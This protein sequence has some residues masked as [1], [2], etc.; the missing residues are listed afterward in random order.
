M[1][2]WIPEAN[3]IFL[4]ALELRAEARQAYLDHVC[5]GDAE[6][7]RQVENLLSASDR[8]LERPQ[9][10]TRL[11]AM[12]TVAPAA[13]NQDDEPKH[14]EAPAAAAPPAAAT[15][16]AVGA[17]VGS[18]KLLQMLG[19]GGMGA[20]W[21]AEQQQPVKRRVA[22]KL[23][24]AGM[25]SA[26]VLRR[27]E[28]ERQTLALM[29]HTNIAKVFDAGRT[30]EG[31]P[32]FA[33]ELIKGVPITHYCDELHLSLAERLELFVPVCQAIQ[34]AHQKG[35]I[36]RDIK[37]SNVLIA[38][39]DGRPVPKVIDFGVAKALH[40]QM[41][42]QSLY[43]EIGAVIGTLE[44]MAPEQA[45]MSALD[46]DTRA[47]V[48]SL[49]VLLYELLTGTTPLDRKRLPSTGY[50]ELLRMI[51]ADDPPK[52]S[53]RLTHSQ[54]SLAKL[55]AQRRTDPRRLT[56]D[57]R[58][59]LDWIV[60]K[61]LEK[62]R[63]RRYEAA[64]ALARDIER[65]LHDDPVEACPPSTSY[66]LKKFMR[67][68]KGPVLAVAALLLLLIAGV[69]GTTWG[70]VRADR[71]RRDAVLSEEAEAKQKQLAEANERK[72]E[73]NEQKASAAAEAERGA[74]KAAQAREAETRA[75]LDFVQQKVFA[76]AR[77]QGEQGGLGRD[78]P[79]GKAVEAALPFLDQSFHDQ[80]LI[81]ARLR[82][83]LGESFLSLGKANIASDQFRRA[84]TI[85]TQHLGRDHPDTLDSMYGVARS[86]SD[87]GRYADALKLHQE[88]LALRRAK[89]GLDHPDTLKSMN[90]TADS[91]FNL[92]RNTEAFRL[93]EETLALQKATL[94]PDH[95]DTL[96]SMN[97]L[98]GS[99]LKFGR[100]AE[101]L[102]LY[103]DT[104]ALR[105]AKLGPDHPKTLGSMNNLAA[106]YF[107]LGRY[108][109]AL[110]LCEETLALQKVKLGA[111]HRDTLH[112]MWNV[113]LCYKELGQYAEAVKLQEEALPLQKAKLG[114]DHP[115]TLDSMNGLAESYRALGRYAD[116]VKLHEETLALRK[117]KLGRDNPDTLRNM[118][119]LANSYEGIGRHAD[120]I[121]LFEETLA[122]QK[123]KVGPD[124]S[125][126][127]MSMN[128]LA[129]SYESV[130]RQTDALKLREDTLK[131][132]K[133][134]LGPD[135]P[136]TLVSMWGLAR[137]LIKLDRGAEA[138]P[139]IDDC[140]H[141]AGSRSVD[142][143]LLPGVMDLRLHYFEKKKDAA[144]CWATAEMWEKLN[145]TDAD[146]LFSAACFRGV[147]AAVIHAR[148]Q[149]VT[150]SKEADVEGARAM[151]WLKKAIAAG[152]NDAAHMKKDNDLAA[153]RDRE[154]FKKLLAELA[155]GKGERKK[156]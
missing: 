28:A 45:E 89:L 151:A 134:K 91:Y 55:A 29:D 33:M 23:I 10:P 43:T 119:N 133:V 111:D 129:D 98:A 52:P 14:P 121:K 74:K 88:T 96:G 93:C 38:I 21:V 79:L 146:S 6:L 30:P 85:Y 66:R 90:K 15:G 41:G 64:S 110:T 137:S 143:G 22:L 17:M 80:P 123:A 39:Q 92:G 138:V 57:V 126:T 19:E 131:F 68:N 26:R 99:Y 109:D 77:P 58:G 35:I 124:H 97:N 1:P 78:V 147:T 31:R 152:Y 84:R 46:V 112:S 106:V 20:V 44:Y 56:K 156:Q 139:I 105:K 154:E 132:R 3:D 53:T 47:D 50:M 70:L 122:L 72:A 61:A 120:A 113:A 125:D 59:E 144:G 103:Q 62:D 100:Y 65:Y 34:H 142:P 83:T 81:E 12:T 73:A 40:Q 76:A 116:A 27:F 102:K 148:A 101:A 82:M 16:E 67:R 54:E 136:D 117:A 11:L 95:P 9:E 153:L 69:I 94:G 48:Y 60:M 49:G 18:Y 140:V 128:N 118:S 71:A 150:T 114:P 155:A 4:H 130:G 149:T 32:F 145:R 86:D 63:T 141:R 7:R 51:K 87:L 5:Q 115:N 8:A 37:P 36:H 42:E 24:K 104:L 13:G 107:S 135:H 2:A 75:V 25:D 108:S 127:L